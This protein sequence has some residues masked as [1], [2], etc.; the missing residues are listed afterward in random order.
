MLRSPLLLSYC[1]VAGLLPLGA[2]AHEDPVQLMFQARALQRR[3]GGDDPEKA[4]ALYRRVIALVPKSGE[5]HLRLS[6]ALME[7]SDIPGALAAA[8]KA[9]QLS[10]RSGEAWANLGLLHYMRGRSDNK[11]WN[12]AIPALQ[13]AHYLLPMDA[14]ILI[15]LA[16]TAE[17]QKQEALATD[18]WLRLGRLRPPMNFQGRPL[19]DIAFERAAI[20][21]A[22]VKDV[23]ARREALVALCQRP[24]PDP[25]HLRMLED[26][27]RE[28][29]DQ[30]FL[31]H[32]EEG[33]SIL[34]VHVPNEPAVYDN[35]A[36]IQFQTGRYAL[37]LENLQ[38]SEALRKH[39][40]T[41]LYIALCQAN[42]GRLEEAETRFRGL[43]GQEDGR[44]EEGRQRR[45]QG[46]E[47][48]ATLLL[49]RG[50]PKEVL[51]LA[52]AWS[53]TR[54]SVVLQGLQAQAHIELKAF[55]EARAVLREGLSTFPERGLFVAAGRL[56]AKLL[57]DGFFNR[58][59][60]E[61]ALQQLHLET[62]AGLWAEFRQ[63]DK[64]LATVM[65]ARKGESPSVID[66]I[67]LQSNALEQLERHD[68]A[69]V[70]LREGQKLAPTHPTLQNN[71]G[72][73]LLERGKEL[74]EA[75]QLIGASLKQD[76][77]SGSTMDS[78]GWVL[79]KQGKFK[80]AEEALKKA[81]DLSPL[82][83]EIRKHY[84]EALLKNGKAQEALNQW[85]R[86]LA[87]VFPDRTALEKRVKDLRL[88]LA[89]KRHAQDLGLPPATE[90]PVEPDDDGG[91]RP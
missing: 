44:T 83:P 27:T 36:L 34:A 75:A 31:A 51:D 19:G 17:T 46:K 7:T 30:G 20:L 14:D 66:L 72:Y 35:L 16:E 54:N 48:L 24:Q 38:R 33:F 76:P 82:S 8:T 60:S 50:K 78:W 39:P 28:L 10:P 26:L 55:K 18:S 58:T 59:A 79:F 84:G 52:K 47:L 71:L 29:A 68:E 21:G 12:E 3:T 88:D 5:A 81:V 70:V 32:A 85:D 56:P 15:R 63:W 77:S 1:L 86:A 41:D 6:E 25:K 62:L 37:A 87:Y 57:Q 43:L 11:A 80:E 2:Q 40:G 64:A 89:R 61:K 73:M 90:E 74:E 13:K 42:L 67:L 49:L 65:E 23:E 9:T 22:K 53:E 91:Q 45:I 4:A 69:L